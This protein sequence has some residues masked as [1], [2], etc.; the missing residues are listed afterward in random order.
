MR[1]LLA[2]VV[3]FFVGGCSTPHSAAPSSPPTSS[4]PTVTVP[5]VRGEPVSKA[6]ET[7]QADGFDPGYTGLAPT[8]IVVSTDPAAGTYSGGNA[9]ISM[10]VTAPT[11]TTAPTVPPRMV[12]VPNV[13]GETITHATS[14][15][16]AVGLSLNTATAYP[17]NIVAYTVPAAGASVP[18]GSDIDEYSCAAGGTPTPSSTGLWSCNPGDYGPTWGGS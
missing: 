10:S 14:S 16:E 2:V 12:T 13:N 11:T 1:K 7:L 6:V 9:Y 5:D 3:V 15:M 8:S 4:G 18:V 17:T